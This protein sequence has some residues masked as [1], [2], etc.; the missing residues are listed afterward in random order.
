[1]KL[2]DSTVLVTGANRGLGRAL[3]ED[4]LARGAKRVY[5][6]SRAASRAAPAEFNDP[7]VVAIAL[8]ITDP[9]SVTAAA[10]KA[11]DVQLL[12]NNAGVFSAGPPLAATDAQLRNDM[13]VNYY[14]LL[15]AV[16]GFRPVLARTH[17]SIVNVLSLVSLANW[18]TFGGYAATKAAAWSLTQALRV[19]LKA[20]GIQV[21]AAFPGM[22]DTDMTRGY[23]GDKA[24]PQAIAHG[25]LDGVEA[26]TLDIAPDATAAGALAIYLKNPN[27]LIRHF[28][29]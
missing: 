11:S 1:M 16:R 14:G 7:R 20:E 29:G 15:N 27:D 26:G 17:G 8:D 18:S 13:D 21:H 19:E 2:K 28:A 12:V 3:V 4:L 10:V 6:A 25:T 23:P 24:T 9:A 5:A 22:I